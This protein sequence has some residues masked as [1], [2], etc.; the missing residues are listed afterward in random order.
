MNI[1]DYFFWSKIILVYYSWIIIHMVYTWHRTVR[2]SSCYFAL[3]VITISIFG[4]DLSLYFDRI[5]VI[6]PYA[7]CTHIVLG[8]SLEA[9]I[10]HN[11][12]DQLR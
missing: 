7:C 12:D 5:V 11:A 9:L 10:P 6:S 3:F 2:L 4:T 1:N 8:A